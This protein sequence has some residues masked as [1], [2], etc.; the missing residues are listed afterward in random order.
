MIIVIEDKLEEKTLE[1]GNSLKDEIDNALIISK[2]DLEKLINSI[3]TIKNSIDMEDIL[4]F[5]RNMLIYLI[6]KIKE[7]F[8]KNLIVLLDE[9]TVNLNEIKDKVKKLDE[10][11]YF[12]RIEESLDIKLNIVKEEKSF[13]IHKDTVEEIKTRILEV[14]KISKKNFQERE[15]VSNKN[16]LV[17]GNNL[18]INLLNSSHQSVKNVY[19]K[20]GFY[21]IILQIHPLVIQQELIIDNLK[22]YINLDYLNKEEIELIKGINKE[23][24][25]NETEVTKIIE[26][27]LNYIK[28]FKKEEEIYNNKESIKNITSIEK[29]INSKTGNIFELTKVFMSIIRYCNIPTKLVFGIINKSLYHSWVEIYSESIGWIPV[30]I[31]NNFKM[32]NEKYYFGITN[33]HIKLFED[34]NFINISEK[35]EKLDISV[36]SINEIYN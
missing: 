18:D 11:F 3:F 28:E 14:L 30:E 26:N 29:I 5:E 20:K 23:I 15:L 9:K 12:F 16:Y 6:K 2:N 25:N 36:I 22:I 10:E 32:K 31:K 34:I 8:S 33:N 19:K 24:N 21:E 4:E 7:K 1:I 35:I 13:I 17:K 27:T